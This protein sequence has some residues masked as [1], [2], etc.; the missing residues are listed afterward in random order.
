MIHE[1][2]IEIRKSNIKNINISIRTN[3]HK[4]IIMLTTGIYDRPISIN[5]QLTIRK[6]SIIRPLL[7]LP[8][9][10][11]QLIN[12]TRKQID[13]N[14]IIRT[15]TIQSPENTHQLTA[16]TR[17]KLT[18]KITAPTQFKHK[19]SLIPQ[20]SNISTIIINK[21]KII[22]TGKHARTNSRLIQRNQTA[23]ANTNLLNSRK[24]IQQTIRITRPNNKIT[25]KIQIQRQN[26]TGK[27]IT[28]QTRK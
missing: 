23:S 5:N 2:M 22:P 10:R 13:N 18:N 24:I 6:T 25:S 15:N 8:N 12:K 21:I 3:I 4:I 7:I 27:T 14:N 16:R 11:I 28:I 17:T 1:N 26:T 9:T 20:I 19:I